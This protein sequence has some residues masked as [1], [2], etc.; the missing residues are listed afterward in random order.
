MCDRLQQPFEST[1]RQ[2]AILREK[3]P[4]GCSTASTKSLS[5]NTGQEATLNLR[6]SRPAGSLVATTPSGKTGSVPMIHTSEGGLWSMLR[7]VTPS[8]PADHA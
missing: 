5:R 2:E 8:Y 7:L 3:Q 6:G 1:K 4:N